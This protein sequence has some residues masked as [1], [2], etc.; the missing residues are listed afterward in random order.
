MAP[1]SWRH[2]HGKVRSHIMRALLLAAL[3]TGWSHWDSRRSTMVLCWVVLHVVPISCQSYHTAESVQHVLN[4]QEVEFHRCM[5]GDRFSQREAR[6]EG[7]CCGPCTHCLNIRGLREICLSSTTPKSCRNGILRVPKN[8]LGFTTRSSDWRFRLAIRHA[9][10]PIVWGAA[11][12]R[13]G[14]G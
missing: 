1:S 2:V 7:R 4:V 11:G 12:V 6:V 3:W 9:F 10:R 13:H 8:A 14:P 5:D